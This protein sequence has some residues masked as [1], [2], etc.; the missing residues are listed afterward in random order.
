MALLA[1]VLCVN[2]AACSD[3]DENEPPVTLQHWQERH[4]RLPPVMK[5]EWREQPLL[6]RQTELLR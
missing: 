4:G 3:D 6:L 5:M 1:V 2:F